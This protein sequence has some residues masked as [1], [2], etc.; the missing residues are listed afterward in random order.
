[1]GEIVD[2]LAGCGLAD[3]HPLMMQGRAFILDRQC[4]DGGWGDQD[5]EY[6]RFHSVWTCI[7]G[8]RD[9]GWPAERSPMSRPR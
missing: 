3:A 6:G 5:D 2:S 1:V 4:A 8:L 9:Y 7:D